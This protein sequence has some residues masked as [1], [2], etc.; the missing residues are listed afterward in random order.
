MTVSEAITVTERA[1]P[2]A[3]TREEKLRW[4]TEVDGTVKAEILDGYEDG[5]ADAVSYGE[6]T[7]PDTVLLIPPP[8]DSAYLFYIES[9]T[10]LAQGEYER[11]NNAVMMFSA[12]LAAFRNEY[13]RTHTHKS[14]KLKFY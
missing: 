6:D 10:E 7:P 8:Y 1:M 3:A 4:L 11:Y 2:G 5:G 14:E 9:R 13:N 12:E